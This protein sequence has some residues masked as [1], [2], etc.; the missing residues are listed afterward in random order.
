MP[1]NYAPERQF[2]ES[3]L[4][5]FAESPPEVQT[6][7]NTPLSELGKRIEFLIDSG[8]TKSEAREQA[9]DELGGNITR[10][11][12]SDILGISKGAVDSNISSA[13]ESLKQSRRLYWMTNDIPFNPISEFTVQAE[14]PADY[15]EEY[16]I[17]RYIIDSDNEYS[18]SKPPEYVIIV[19]TYAPSHFA[20]YVSN[21]VDI[22][23]FNSEEE[24]IDYLYRDEYFQSI[25]RARE[26]KDRLED[27]FDVH[28][29]LKPSERIN[30]DFK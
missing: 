23:R 7:L 19:E 13:R 18:Q 29:E 12:R 10:K 14:P 27:L 11:T 3:V 8:L 20:S 9:I 6:N 25:E 4:E 28:I 17:G 30:P 21:G 24:I 1:E 22:E 15:H 2:T 5:A 16:L 26:W